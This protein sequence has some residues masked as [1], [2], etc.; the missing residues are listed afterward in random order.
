MVADLLTAARLGVS[1]ILP[2]VLWPRGSLTAAA[3]LV[4]AAWISDVVDG[5]LARYSG[6]EGRLGHWDLTADTAVG[7]GVVVGLAGAGAVPAWYAVS[8]LFLLGAWFLRTRS[9]ASSMILQLS[10]YVPLLWTLL[11]EQA[12]WWW[13]PFFAA[14]LIGLVDWRRLIEVNVPGFLR[15]VTPRNWRRVT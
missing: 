10:G 13:L 8:A 14:L 12:D 11:R 3:V 5:R 1:V 2:A 6:G 9:L 7:A 15:S 4:S